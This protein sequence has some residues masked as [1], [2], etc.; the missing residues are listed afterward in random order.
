MIMDSWFRRCNKSGVFCPRSD[1][2]TRNIQP[3][4][5]FHGSNSCPRT[6]EKTSSN[7]FSNKVRYGS[8]HFQQYQFYKSYLVFHS[9]ESSS[10]SSSLVLPRIR[11]RNSKDM[12]PYTM[13]E[14]I[15]MRLADVGYLVLSTS[16]KWN[17]CEKP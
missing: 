16:L 3:F 13:E 11:S 15:M 6:I 8:F 14:V 1:T 5:H 4:A 10:S 9:I 12:T 17:P 7:S 2:I